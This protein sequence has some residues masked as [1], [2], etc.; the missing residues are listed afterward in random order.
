VHPYV[1]QMKLRLHLISMVSDVDLAIQTN[2]L[3]TEQALRQGSAYGGGMIMF[4]PSWRPT[5]RDFLIGVNAMRKMCT[6][7][8]THGGSNNTCT[9]GTDGCNTRGLVE[10]AANLARSSRWSVLLSAR[11]FR[12]K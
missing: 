1:I 11:R 8:G 6:S 7:T 10:P 3:L 2:G 5:P 9:V 4:R 12:A